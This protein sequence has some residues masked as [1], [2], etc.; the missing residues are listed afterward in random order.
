MLYFSVLGVDTECVNT[1]GSYKCMCRN[2]FELTSNGSC[3][4]EIIM[5]KAKASKYKIISRSIYSVKV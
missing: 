1:P 4:G 3:I 2:G 5:C